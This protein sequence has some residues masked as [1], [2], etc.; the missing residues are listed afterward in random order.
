VEPHNVHA[1]GGLL[2]STRCATEGTVRRYANMLFRSSSDALLGG[3]AGAWIAQRI[4]RHKW[5][6]T[7]YMIVL[8]AIVA[9]HAV[10]WMWWFGI[11]G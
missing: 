11:F 2:L 4:F 8:W 5:K 7:R 9:T 6:K 10:A 3:W 1:V